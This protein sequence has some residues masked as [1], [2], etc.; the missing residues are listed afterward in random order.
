MYLEAKATLAYSIGSETKEMVNLHE[1]FF[2]KTNFNSD[3]RTG[4]D[5]EQI[6]GS[7]P[8][9]KS[10]GCFRTVGEALRLTFI[11]EGSLRANNEKKNREIAFLSCTILKSLCFNFLDEV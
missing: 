10:D 11:F 5:K 4:I 3:G 2:W 8:L 7:G 9:F 6:D 1:F